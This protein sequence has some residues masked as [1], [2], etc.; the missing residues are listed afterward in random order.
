MEKTPSIISLRSTIFLSNGI[1]Y[2]ADNELK[3]RKLLPNGKVKS[4]LPNTLHLE[5]VSN[6]VF[7]PGVNDSWQLVDTEKGYNIVFIQ[8]KID[9]IYVKKNQVKDIEKE[10][11]DFT[12]KTF[13]T[14]MDEVGYV[15]RIAYSPTYVFDPEEGFPYPEYWKRILLSNK[16][17]G[18]D[19]QDIN[20]QYLLKKEW[21]DNEN[22]FGINL[23]HNWSDAIKTQDLKEKKTQSKCI[24]L[25]LDINTV[26]GG[27]TIF[28]EQSLEHFFR[29]MPTW[30]EELLKNY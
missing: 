26:P 5:G 11:I 17:E 12:I 16:I 19:M 9:L 22:S 3:Y 21:K 14:I 25:N 18:M 8:N 1:G 2:S 24:T 15:V 23:L 28:Y 4:V 6:L 7:G 10:F 30:V 13:R 27:K 29:E 20:I